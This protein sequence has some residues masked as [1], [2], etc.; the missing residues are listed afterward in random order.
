MIILD[1]H[2]WVWWV[3]QDEKELS[4]KKL[5]LLDSYIPDGLG[6]CV[7]SCLEV[8]QKAAKGKLIIEPSSVSEKG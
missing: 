3:N 6:V 7:I 2:I 1:T 4:D 5:L 8:A